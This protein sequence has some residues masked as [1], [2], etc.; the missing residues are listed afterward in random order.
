M[1]SDSYLTP[2]ELT[3]QCLTSVLY[4]WV[5]CWGKKS[6]ASVYVLEKFS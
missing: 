3:G 5:F 2:I 4:V 6:Q 1:C